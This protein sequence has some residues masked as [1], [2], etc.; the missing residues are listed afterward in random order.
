MLDALDALA[1]QH[2]VHTTTA[3]TRSVKDADEAAAVMTRLRSKAP[4]KLC[5]FDVAMTDLAAVR[6]YERRTDAV[7]LEGGDTNTTV[8][9]AVRPSGTEPKVKS[10]IEVRQHCIDGNLDVA[11]SEAQRIQDELAKIATRW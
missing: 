2:G 3:V 6:P 9:V 1:R 5:G 11:R 7:I 4:T 8:R 10:Y